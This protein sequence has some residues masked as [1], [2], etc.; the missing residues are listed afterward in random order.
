[1]DG[2]E[3]ALKDRFWVKVNILSKEECWNWQSALDHKGYGSFS[4][5][6]LPTRRA[7]RISWILSCGNI[8]DG[9]MVL[10]KCDNPSCVNPNHLYLGT[11]KDNTQ[12]MMSKRRG[13]F[14][15]NE[16][17]GKCKVPTEQVIFAREAYRNK[18]HSAVQLANILGV[19][20]EYIRCIV[21]GK[22]RNYINE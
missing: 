18:T 17:H 4:N 6:V 7:N 3:Q 9:L 20:P 1:M 12:D 11:A 13:V 21:S 2:L 19:T 22:R 14:P 8:P 10:H 15:T 5:V 16:R